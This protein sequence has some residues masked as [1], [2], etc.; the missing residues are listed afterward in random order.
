MRHCSLSAL[1]TLALALAL[2][3]EST[4]PPSQDGTGGGDL[5]D[6][7]GG[8]SEVGSGGS[9]TEGSGGAPPAPPLPR[10]ACGL[11]LFG[12]TGQPAP[13][14]EVGGL[15]IVNWAGAAFAASYTFDDSNSSQISAYADLQALGVP[16]TFYLQTGKDES[17][18]A[19]WAQALEDG[20]ELGNHTESHQQT[21]TGVDIDAATMFIEETFGV[22]PMTMAA[23][24]GDDSY[25]PLAEE[26]FFINRGVPGGS[27]S[28]GDSRNPFDLPCYVPAKDALATTLNGVMDTAR[29]GGKWQLMLVH[30]FTGGSDAAYQPVA[31]SEF[32]A[33]VEYTKSLGDGWIDT[34]VAVGAYYLGQRAVAAAETATEG[35]ST[36]WTWTLPDHFPAD[37]C[38][39]VVV[40]GGTLTQAGEAVPWDEHGYYEIDLDAGSLTL[41]P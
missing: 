40:D 7:T 11:P 28:P 29:S 3:C 20:H 31:L 23:P 4:D 36:T 33:H 15:Q 38:I 32:L 37:K 9:S 12:E 41:A 10:S 39:R 19:V 1:G 24:Y 16:M 26:R 25:I 14:G 30:G 5:Q 2:G 6:G 13:S 27:L 21:G 18:D 22:A 35:E 17:S 8:Q 34:V